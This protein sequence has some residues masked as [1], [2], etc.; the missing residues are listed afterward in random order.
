M[1]KYV[2]LFVITI[3]HFSINGAQSQNSKNDSEKGNLIYEN[4]LSLGIDVKDWI[5]EGPAKV[6]FKD[7]WMQM[8][9]PE[10]I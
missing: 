10:E 9:S 3:A 5:L 8:F 7:T 1:I 6:E 4:P 2:F